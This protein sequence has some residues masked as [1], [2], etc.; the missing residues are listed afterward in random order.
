M[1]SP[2]PSWA[3]TV[4]R[5]TAYDFGYSYEDVIGRSK[6]SDLPHVRRVAIGRLRRR[7]MSL[8]QIGAAMGGRDH[9]S[10]VYSLKKG[11]AA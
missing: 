3:E 9:A 2:V 10:I 7:G 5:Q 6:I 1:S 11:T 4:I 8:T